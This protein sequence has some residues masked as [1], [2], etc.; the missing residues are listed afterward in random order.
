[1][2]APEITINLQTCCNDKIPQGKELKGKKGSQFQV[3][4]MAEGKSEWQ[5]PEAIN[6]IATM[7]K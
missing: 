5:K 1:M 7:I 3:I 4:N 6:H 2:Q